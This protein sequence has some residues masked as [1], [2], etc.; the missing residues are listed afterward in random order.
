MV[1][2]PT[3]EELK[4][5]LDVTSGDFDEHL[6]GLLDAGIAQAKQSRGAWDEAVD[7]PDEKLHNAAL[8]AAILMR[9]N[10]PTIGIGGPS[11]QDV[12]S[13]PG[14]QSLLQG[15]RRRFQIG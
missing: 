6:G 2:W 10:A 14:Y 12:E 8:R 7:V 5:L 1:D 15:K 9:P 3:L 11:H 13:D 4:A